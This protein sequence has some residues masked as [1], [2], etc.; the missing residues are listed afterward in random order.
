MFYFANNILLS[1]QFCEINMQIISSKPHYLWIFCFFSMKT[2][3]LPIPS[4]F[5]LSFHFLFD[6]NGTR[7]KK[8]RKY[9]CSKGNKGD[10]GIICKQITLLSSIFRVRGLQ[11]WTTN[12]KI[13]VYLVSSD[14]DCHV[15]F[16]CTFWPYFLKLKKN[17]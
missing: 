8:I 2:Q 13:G 14:Q 5:V 4:T 15:F 6:K 16:E 9:C 3:D 12:F 1:N 17:Y 11:S 7:I 10:H